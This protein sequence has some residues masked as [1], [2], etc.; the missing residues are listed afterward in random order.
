[1]FAAFCNGKVERRL[2]G[3]HYIGN[4]AAFLAGHERLAG[5]SMNTKKRKLVTHAALLRTINMYEQGQQ[6]LSLP[7]AGSQPTINRRLQLAVLVLQPGAQTHAYNI[8]TYIYICD[9]PGKQSMSDRKCPLKWPSSSG[10]VSRRRARND[11]LL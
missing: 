3:D 1:M 5:N 7:A 11:G 2:L 4:R 8:Y 10:T 6:C 9:I